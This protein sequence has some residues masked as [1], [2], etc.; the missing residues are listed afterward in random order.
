MRDDYRAQ[1]P[2][3]PKTVQ[4]G[5]NKF[6]VGED[7]ALAHQLQGSNKKLPLILNQF[8]TFLPRNVDF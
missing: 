5:V 3:V 6:R 4:E 8:R 1:T 7:F 2:S